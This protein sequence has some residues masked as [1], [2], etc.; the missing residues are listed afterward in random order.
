MSELNAS[1]MA[2]EV[3]FEP[4]VR[5]PGTAVFK[6]AAFNHS[7]TPPVPR[8]VR[9]QRLAQQSILRQVD[10][11]GGAR[12]AQRMAPRPL[13]SEIDRLYQLPLDE[14]TSA[15]NALAKTSGSDAA[16]IARS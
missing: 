16:R 11:R 3:G 6:T 2:E 12:Y 4:T 8:V 9:D 5:F 10:W 15:R 1:R 7:A 14:F 13:D